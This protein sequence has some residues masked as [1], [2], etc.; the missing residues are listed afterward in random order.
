MSGKLFYTNEEL[1]AANRVNIVAFLQGIGYELIREGKRYR[2]KIHD[3]LIINEDGSWFWNSKGEGEYSPVN[4]YKLILLQDYGYTNEMEA[5]I[6]AIKR[7][8]S[9]SF[10][11]E[12]IQSTPLI[13]SRPP[14]MP[15]KL[16]E[17]NWNNNRALAYLTYTRKLDF[18]IVQ[19]LI[20]QGKI[21]EDAEHHNVCFV[22]YDR[23]NRPQNAFMR[24][25]LTYEGRQF[26]KNVDLSDKSYPFTLLGYEN[27][28]ILICFESCIDLISHA[29]IYKMRGLDWR[30]SHRIALSGIGYAGLER[31]L[32]ENPQIANVAVALDNDETGN[33]RSEILIRELSFKYYAAKREASRLKDWNADL[34]N[35]KSKSLEQLR[36][37]AEY[38]AEF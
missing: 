4:L 18:D 27:S 17:P 13:S 26:K 32:H 28:T 37:E 34:I 2:G 11:H 31:F 6:T 14:N 24:G 5:A 35:L 33:R 29:T 19:E 20:E 25:T 8:A 7:L 10:T 22:A 23:E 38:E 1:Q 36:E 21:Y 15:L 30:D 12:N 3:S 16:P 9:S